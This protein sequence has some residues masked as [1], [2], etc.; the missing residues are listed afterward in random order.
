MALSDAQQLE[1]YNI[2]KLIG[3]QILGQTYLT[4]G[5][6]GWPT[7]DGQKTTVVDMLRGLYP[8]KAPTVD[9]NALAAALLAALTPEA[10][11]TLAGLVL[12]GIKAQMAAP[13][14]PA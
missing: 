9:V 13:L 4:D 11:K 5:Q 10:A 1:V 6:W 8:P 7:A 3:T 12:D 2:T 14:P